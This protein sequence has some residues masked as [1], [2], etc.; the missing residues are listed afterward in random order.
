MNDSVSKTMLRRVGA[1][2]YCFLFLT[3]PSLR[4]IF[5]FNLLFDSGRSL[6]EQRQRTRALLKSVHQLLEP[7]FTPATLPSII[8]IMGMQRNPKCIL[9]YPLADG[10]TQTL[11][12]GKKHSY[13]AL[14]VLVLSFLF[15]FSSFFFGDGP[16][17][18]CSPAFC[19]LM[20]DG[21]MGWD[22]WM[23]YVWAV[24]VGA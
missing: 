10:K 23:A 14:C 12:T 21:C 9:L 24:I 22:A 3:F 16:V 17:S 2:A 20:Y 7:C 5:P 1:K 4:L 13:L 11:I 19:G 15:F 8:L 6:I 18:I